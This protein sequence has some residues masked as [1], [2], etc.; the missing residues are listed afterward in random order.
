MST[1]TIEPEVAAVLK[2]SVI[3]STS[4]TLPPG[5]LNRTLYVKVNSVI[6]RAGG[7][8]DKKSKTHTFT[9]DPRERLGV[10]TE[11]GVIGLDVKVAA[12]KLVEKIKKKELQAFFAPKELA[13]RVV[14]L[15]EVSGMECLEPSAGTGSLVHAMKRAGASLI[16][17]VEIDEAHVKELYKQFPSIDD[18]QIFIGQATDFLSLGAS[19]LAPY[20]RIVMN[21]PFSK[22]Q[23]IKHVSHALSF[24]KDGGIL[25]AIMSPNTERAGFK[26]LVEG[27]THE[28][29]PV[30][31]G[32]FKESGTN[33]STIILKIWG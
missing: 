21:P 7:V 6:E 14:E 10:A 16:H 20:D 1:L 9:S 33:V 30:E 28:I 8:W 24:L 29:Y 3:T 22:N 31:Q 26:K 25:V 17:C 15:A 23:D 13:D 19:D 18:H 4:L 11:T 27:K 32:A 2:N 12:P 5:N